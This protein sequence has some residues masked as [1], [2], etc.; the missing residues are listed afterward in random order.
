MQTKEKKR[1]GRGGCTKGG[2]SIQTRKN[3]PEKR[4]MTKILTGSYRTTD[5]SGEENSNKRKDT[6]SQKKD[7]PSKKGDTRLGRLQ[8]R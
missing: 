2:S 7:K 3:K 1:A 8:K 6:E 4:D 5:Q